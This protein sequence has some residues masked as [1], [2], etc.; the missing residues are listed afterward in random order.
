MALY[1]SNNLFPSHNLYPS[2]VISFDFSDLTNYNNIRPSRKNASLSS[3]L[4]DTI[5]GGREKTSNLDSSPE[6]NRLSQSRIIGNKIK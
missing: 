3:N 4:E 5:I 6:N 2:L 1:P